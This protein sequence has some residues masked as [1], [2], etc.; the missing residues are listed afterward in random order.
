[1]IHKALST[2]IGALPPIGK[3][4]RIQG[5]G[6][7][8]NYRGIDDLMPAVRKVF[9]D[10][11]IH[12]ASSFTVLSDGEVTVGRSGAIWTRVVVQGCFTFYATDGSSVEVSTIG[13]GRDNGDKAYN[14]AMTVAWKYAL[15]QALAV[16]DGD[17][18]DAVPS[19]EMEQPARPGV[20]ASGDAKRR[21]VTVCGG[22]ADAAATLWRS[23]GLA[24]AVVDGGVPL[25]MLERVERDSAPI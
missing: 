20:V 13:E 14:K 2:A 7:S 23:S 12:A 16:S 25:E 11:G 4:S 18:P 10:I 9:A 5:S 1:M 15:V 24:E 22:D 19:M 8:Y 3:N 6:P 17:D 21:L